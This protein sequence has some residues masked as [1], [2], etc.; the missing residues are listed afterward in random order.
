M[1]SRPKGPFRFPWLS[2]LLGA[3][4]AFGLQRSTAP[5]SVIA[6]EP[7]ALGLPVPLVLSPVTGPR[8][9]P[10]RDLGAETPEPA[11]EEQEEALSE[12]LVGAR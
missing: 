1:L 7:E 10:I 2:A 8:D 11:R 12:S 6:A 9:T 4:I 5:D 3:G